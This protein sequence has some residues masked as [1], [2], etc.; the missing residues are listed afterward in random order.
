[1]NYLALQG[2]VAKPQGTGALAPFP[3]KPILNH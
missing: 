2:E 1:M 3:C